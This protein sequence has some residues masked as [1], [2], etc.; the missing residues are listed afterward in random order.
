MASKLIE[1]VVA[2]AFYFVLGIGTLL[3][4]AAALIE[5]HHVEQLKIEGEQ[6]KTDAAKA[7]AEAA[8]AGQVAGDARLEAAR[9]HERAA[10][11]EVDAERQRERAAAQAERA[12]VAERNLLALKE[13]LEPRTISSQGRAPSWRG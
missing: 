1:I 3:T 8:R 7:N 4:V 11:L 5:H 2:N 6:L 10:A 12:A 9:A 13:R